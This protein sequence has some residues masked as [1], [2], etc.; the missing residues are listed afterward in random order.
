MAEGET[1]VFLGSHSFLLE[2]S[3]I[4]YLGLS[5]DFMVSQPPGVHAHTE[6]A[7]KL[8]WKINQT[9]W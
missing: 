4:G 8:L 3:L 6:T 5:F 1:Q 9:A 7:L 2:Q